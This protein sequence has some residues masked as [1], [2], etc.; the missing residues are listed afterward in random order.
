MTTAEK[1]YNVL[2]NARTQQGGVLIKAK[3]IALADQFLDVERPVRPP[4]R[5]KVSAMTDAE[6]I[7]AIKQDPAMAGIN[8]ERELGKCRFWCKNNGK[9]FT[10]RRAVNWLNKADR[11]LERFGSG[12]E[13]RRASLQERA[14]EAPHGWQEFMKGK[15]REW[16]AENGAG[17]DHPGKVAL[18]KGD[19]FGM[20][21]SWRDEAR[22]ALGGG[23]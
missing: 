23:T 12:A 18:E 21:K 10:R 17:Y 9:G 8:V 15:A 11:A 14:G 2:A 16:E 3:W 13:E 20:P 5:K 19:F 4:P 6:W 7:A 1:L 22:K